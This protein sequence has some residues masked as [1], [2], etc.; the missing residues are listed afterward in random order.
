MGNAK[1]WYHLGRW[2][3]AKTFELSTF[4]RVNVNKY[5][6]DGLTKKN[7]LL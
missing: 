4:V 3:G 2:V 7:S 6:H 5:L 1:R